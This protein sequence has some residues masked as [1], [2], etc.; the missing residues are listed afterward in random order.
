MF[1][2]LQ[3]KGVPLCE[4]RVTTVDGVLD[5]TRSFQKQE[6]LNMV[7]D[8]PTSHFTVPERARVISPRLDHFHNHIMKGHE[9]E[10]YSSCALGDVCT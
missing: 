3:K 1:L 5:V 9:F 6:H 2:Q 4:Y 7:T 10:Y 8:T